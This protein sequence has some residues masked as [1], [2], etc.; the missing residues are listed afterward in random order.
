MIRS[1]IK[2]MRRS[3]IKIM[4][5]SSSLLVFQLQLK[6]NTGACRDLR[7]ESKGRACDPF[8]CNEDFEGWKTKSPGCRTQFGVLLFSDGWFLN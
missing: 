1:L 4:R 5:R 7:R 2:I 3:L 6:N 8:D